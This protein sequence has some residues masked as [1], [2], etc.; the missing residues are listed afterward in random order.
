MPYIK[1][2]C[3]AGNTI[4]VRKYFTYGTHPKGEKRKKRINESPERI[5]NA[6]QRNASRKLRRL[7]NHNFK[8]GDYLVRMDFCGEKKPTG[9][10]TMQKE[11]Q[12]FIR[13][14]RNRFKKSDMPLK[15]I[16]VKEVGAKGSRHIH[17]IMNKCEIEWIRS[18]W[19]VGAIHIDPLYSEGQ[20]SKIAD[21]FIKYAK[22]TEETEGML[23]GKRWY[24]SQNLIE[25]KVKKKKIAAGR[26]KKEI[27]PPQGYY[28]DKE[29]ISEG[30]SELT[31]YEYFS[32]TFIKINTKKGG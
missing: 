22:K 20:Y 2:T 11:M 25:P 32:Y 17:M 16:Y 7:M 12:N 9:S 14:L 26:F 21:Y 30:I 8:D 31:G 23:I 10:E 28:L 6:N 13:R 5:K 29:S 4:E 24:A 27:K 3:K 1:E 19:K 15:Y 18:S